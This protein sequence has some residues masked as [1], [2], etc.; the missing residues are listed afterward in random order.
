MATGY[1]FAHIRNVKVFG[2]GDFMEVSHRAQDGNVDT[3][4][5]LKAYHDIGFEGYVRPDHG[6]HLWEKKR[7]ADLVMDCMTEL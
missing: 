7:C 5:V 3:I 6:R 4:E 1:I 2:N